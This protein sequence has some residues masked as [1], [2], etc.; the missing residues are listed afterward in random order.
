VLPYKH[1][2]V[3]SYAH[4]DNQPLLEGERG[5]VDDLH[6]TLAVRVAQLFGQE[7]D[8]WRDPQLPGNDDFA[9]NITLQLPEWR[10]CRCWCSQ[11]PRRPKRTR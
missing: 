7:P 4:I 10:R 9:E 1:D 11:R 2:I 8:I 3:I 6:K 5:W